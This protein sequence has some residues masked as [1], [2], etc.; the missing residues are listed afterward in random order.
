MGSKGIGKRDASL[1]GSA[2]HFLHRSYLEL[3]RSERTQNKMHPQ[4]SKDRELMVGGQEGKC[5]QNNEDGDACGKL[6]EESIWAGI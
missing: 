6:E 1:V 5:K 2:I 4:K 3:H